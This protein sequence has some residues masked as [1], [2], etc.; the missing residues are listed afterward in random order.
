VVVQSAG[1]EAL[2]AR[3]R[4]ELEASGL[5]AFEV[6]V[7]GD[8][9]G[10]AG[11]AQLARE[12]GARA[13]LRVRGVQHGVELW[14]ANGEDGVVDVIALREGDAHAGEVLALG[15]VET[16]RARGLGGER[17]RE[18]ATTTTSATR[19]TSTPTPTTDAAPSTSVES[20]RDRDSDG[21]R[22]W[23]EVA[24]AIGVSPGGLGAEASAFFGVR[25]QPASFVSIG[26]FGFVPLWREALQ[27]A[28][29]SATVSTWML[30]LA[31]DGHLRAG[32]FELAAGAGIASAIVV[33]RGEARATFD[34]VDET[35]RVAAPLLRTSVHL[36]L[37]S[38]RLCLRVHGG[39]SVPLARVRFDERQVARWGQPFVA[40]SLGAELPL[41][42]D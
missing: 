41:A 31:I 33:M 19:T 36:P 39:V 32:A 6:K 23:V 21:R 28:E 4:N 10:R 1:D 16:L 35:E 12:H 3:I 27:A 25:Y 18:R 24:P 30:G 20:T 40:F 7:E 13:A 37:G 15:V 29:G 5:S 42:L 11:L 34:G 14:T 17:E 26:G 22:V 9:G 2:L 8:P 38:V